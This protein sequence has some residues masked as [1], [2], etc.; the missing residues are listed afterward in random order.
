MAEGDVVEHD[1]ENTRYVLKRGDR[2]IGQAVYQ[3]GARGEI[4]FVHTT[5][6]EELQEKGLGSLLA[7]SALDDVR[8]NSGARVVASC[9][10]IDSFIAEHAEYQDLTQRPT[11]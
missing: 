8:E 10:F 3:R 2:E 6:A 11:S 1:A 4:D 9:P 5:V 7:S